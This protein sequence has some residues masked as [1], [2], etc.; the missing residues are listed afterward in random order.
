M[1][2]QGDTEEEMVSA[3][4]LRQEFYRRIDFGVFG[5]SDEVKADV[6]EVIDDIIDIALA[7]PP[8]IRKVVDALKADPEIDRLTEGRIWEGHP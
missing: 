5:T 2:D 8:L 3:D 6:K 7:E 4:R 1:T